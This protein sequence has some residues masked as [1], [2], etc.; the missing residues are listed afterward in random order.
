MTAFRKGLSKSKKPP[1][2][3][4]RLRNVSNDLQKK[5]EGAG[6]DPALSEASK[7]TKEAV[8]KDITRKKITSDF[9]KKTKLSN[10]NTKPNNT[11]TKAKYKAY[12]NANY[13]SLSSFIYEKKYTDIE[14]KRMQDV[15][16][17]TM[18]NFQKDI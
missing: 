10:P 11:A 13:K 15:F 14:G 12:S 16:D 4:E 5:Y 1:S 17:Y 18:V 7:K 9:E 3:R 2:H 8:R 6:K